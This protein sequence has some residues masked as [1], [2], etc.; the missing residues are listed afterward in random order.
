MGSRWHLVGTRAS[1]LLCCMRLSRGSWYLREGIGRR[2]SIDGTLTG[3]TR[4][5]RSF[6]AALCGHEKWHQCYQQAA[7]PLPMGISGSE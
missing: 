5:L 3:R 7:A 6:G 4:D 1:W 2:C